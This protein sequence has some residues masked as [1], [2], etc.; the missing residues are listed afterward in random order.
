LTY[1]IPKSQYK[2][3]VKVRGQ[4]I[5]GVIVDPLEFAKW[6]GVI[7]VSDEEVER[8]GEEDSGLPPDA[9]ESEWREQEKDIQ[10]DDM[11]KEIVEIA[12]YVMNAIPN[13]NYQVEAFIKQVKAKMGDNLPLALEKIE[14]LLNDGILQSHFNSALQMLRNELE[15]SKEERE[16]KEETKG[17]EEKRE[18]ETVSKEE[19]E[20]ESESKGESEGEE[21]EIEDIYK[22]ADEVKKYRSY[23]ELL[24]DLLEFVDNLEYRVDPE[25]W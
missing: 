8:E 15:A 17:K 18:E 7:S 14:K 21:E 23:E 24:K 4:K 11:E 5:S 13:L 25:N 16:R 2:P 19:S 3:K 12:N 20:G 1:F 6:L 22:T 10:L 9:P